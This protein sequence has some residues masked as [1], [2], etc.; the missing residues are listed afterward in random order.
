MNASADAPRRPVFDPET[1]PH[2]PA[3]ADPQV[4]GAPVAPDRLRPTALRRLFAVPRPWEPELRADPRLWMP[5]L[6]ARPAAVLVPLIAREHGMQVLLTQ[7]TAHLSDHAGQI[8]FPGGRVEERDVDATAAALR[9]AQEE[10]GL[11]AERVEV[12]GRLPQYTTVT[13][14]EVTPV[15]GLVE[16]PFDLSLDAFEVSEVFEVPLEFLMNPAHHERRIVV[17]GEMSRTF[18]AMPY[19]AQRRYFIWGATAAMLRNLYHFLR[20]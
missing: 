5:D 14:Y 8:S 3:F 4:R 15:V 18:Y 11:P 2:D 6:E 16:G 7:R 10:V 13:G 19:E 1:I 17:L 12:I 20:A 9:E